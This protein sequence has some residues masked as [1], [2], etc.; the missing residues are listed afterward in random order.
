MV[1]GLN[2]STA[3]EDHDD[4]TVKRCAERAKALGFPH[5]VMTNIFAYRATDPTD[6]LRAPDP[7]GPE[8]DQWLSRLARKAGLIL[9]AWGTDGSHMQRGQA[10]AE[11]LPDLHCL[12]TNLD[13]SP[14]HPLYVS[15]HQAPIPY[16][17]T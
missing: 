1:I 3:T 2:P 10:V 14:K 9:A 6:M 16:S 8:N 12:G 11:L 7:I 5:F 17:P 15:Y 13:G 4:P